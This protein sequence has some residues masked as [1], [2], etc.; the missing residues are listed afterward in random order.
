MNGKVKALGAL[1][2]G[3]LWDLQADSSYFEWLKTLMWVISRE[4]EEARPNSAE[5]IK[6]LADIGNYLAIDR[7]ATVNDICKRLEESLD[8]NGGVQ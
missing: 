8:A 5:R 1:A 3:A 4:A 6:N 2:H 7:A